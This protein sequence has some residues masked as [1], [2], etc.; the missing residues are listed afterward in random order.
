VVEAWNERLA[1]WEHTTIGELMHLVLWQGTFA[2][3]F[4]RAGRREQRT[5]RLGWFCLR[6]P[7]A[8]EPLSLRV[9]GNLSGDEEDAVG[10]TVSVS[11]GC[12]LWCFGFNVSEANWDERMTAAA[13]TGCFGDW[14]KYVASPGCWAFP[15]PPAR[16]RLSSTRLWIITAF[17]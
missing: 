4:Q 11:V 1:H 3:C 10:H 6:L 16:S 8:P 5:L 17:H 13:Y 15:R 12:P 9:V 7:E 2:A 14:P